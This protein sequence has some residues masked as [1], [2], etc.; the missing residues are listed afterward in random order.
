MKRGVLL[1]LVACA[2]PA[3]PSTSNGGGGGSGSTVTPTVV[4]TTNATTCAEL[5]SKIEGLYR[6]E[7][8]QKEP[9]RVD[10]AVSDNTTMVMNDC[11]KD[12][13]KVVACLNKAAT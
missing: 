4:P 10:E 1:L 12:P 9:K 5:K 3:K 6:T 13:G 11:N 8:Q 7:A 2:C